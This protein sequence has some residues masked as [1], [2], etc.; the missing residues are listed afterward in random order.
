MFKRSKLAATL[1][2]LCC[3]CVGYATAANAEWVRC[4]EEHGYCATPFPTIVRYGARGVYA[5]LHT[6]GG[7]IPCNNEVFGDP[8]VGVVKHCEFWARD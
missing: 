2:V 7:G 6:R 3:L 4:A 8:L 1:S 5:R